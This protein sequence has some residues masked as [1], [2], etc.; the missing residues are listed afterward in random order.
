[1]LLCFP[2]SFPTSVPFRCKRKAL[3]KSSPI[4]GPFLHLDRN[5][6]CCFHC[7]A[8]TGLSI[9]NFYIVY[10]CEAKS[11][12]KEIRN[13]YIYIYLYL[14]QAGYKLVDFPFL[15]LPPFFDPLLVRALRFLLF[16]TVNM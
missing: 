3:M 5:R 16:N 4:Y 6:C 12:F 13:I 15:S 11:K 14:V 2:D 7:S 9:P 8:W 1:M 10:F